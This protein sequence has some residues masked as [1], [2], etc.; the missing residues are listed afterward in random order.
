NSL[1]NDIQA[2]KSGTAI[3]PGDTV[4]DNPSTGNAP[5]IPGTN[6]GISPVDEILPQNDINYWYDWYAM[7]DGSPIPLQKQKD[8]NRFFAIAEDRTTILYEVVEISKTAAE[9]TQAGTTPSLADDQM[10]NAVLL[11]VTTMAVL[12]A[13]GVSFLAFDYKHRWEQEIVAQNNRLLG[14]GAMQGTL[15]E[16]D[17]LEPETLRFSPHDYRPLDDSFDH[18][19]RTIA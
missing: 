5:P 9:Q 8:S 6:A 1:S 11:I 2:A 10:R 15:G 18:S 3:Q 16:L 19:F 14:Q 17:L 12:A 7:K 13:F 4:P